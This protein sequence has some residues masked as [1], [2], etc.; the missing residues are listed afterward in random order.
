MSGQNLTRFYIGYLDNGGIRSVIY[1]KGVKTNFQVIK[2]EKE[3]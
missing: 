3:K 1:A 2:R